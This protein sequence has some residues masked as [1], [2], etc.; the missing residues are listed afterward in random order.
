MFVWLSTV[1]AALYVS[2]QPLVVFLWHYT[3]AAL[4]PFAPMSECERMC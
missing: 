4:L 3:G 1:G 2:F